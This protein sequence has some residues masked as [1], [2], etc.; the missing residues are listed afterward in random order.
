MGDDYLDAAERHYQDAQLLFTQSTP[1]WANASHLFGISAECALKAIASQSNP[2][3]KFFGQKG[4]LPA[5]FTELLNV[6]PYIA[7]NAELA[8]HIEGL[9]PSFAHWKVEQRYAA[10]ATFDAAVVGEQQR[11]AH[12]AQKLMTNFLAGLI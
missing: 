9:V 5:L 3:V 6:A 4:H 12:H 8:A 2:E 7:G 1:R 11:G 10:Q